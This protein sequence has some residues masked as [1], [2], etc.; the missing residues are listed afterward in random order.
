MGLGLRLERYFVNKA[1][2]TPLWQS[3]AEYVQPGDT[4]AEIF[5][6]NRR[7]V[8]LFLSE[9][10]GETGKVYGVD[11][12]NYRYGELK[13]LERVSN[14]EI[15]TAEIP[16]IPVNGLDVM[17]FRQAFFW[18]C[19]GID[20]EKEPERCL[21][22]DP[23]KNSVLS[24]AVKSGGYMILTLDWQWG[25]YYKNYYEETIATYP[26]RFTKVLDQRDLLIYQKE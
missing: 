18:T 24:S 23:K 9:A 10:V 17:L 12:N 14:I 26:D 3:V 5:N 8:L 1:F 20:K 6:S 11:K 4:A 25:Q 22:F 2:N 16:P 19:V 15:L 21:V 13:P 7:D